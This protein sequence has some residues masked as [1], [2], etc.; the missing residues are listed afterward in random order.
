MWV[1]IKMIGFIL[2]TFFGGTVGAVT[3]AFCNAAKNADE[4]MNKIHNCKSS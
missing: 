1:V 2:G 3:M 4:K